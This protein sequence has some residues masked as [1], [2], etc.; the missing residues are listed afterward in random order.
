VGTHACVRKK[1]EMTPVG[2]MCP[3]RGIRFVVGP[4]PFTHAPGLLVLTPSL[5][6]VYMNESASRIM[7][8]LH[9][10]QHERFATDVLPGQVTALC[11]QA[12]MASHTL[13]GAKVCER[14]EYGTV[15]YSNNRPIRFHVFMVSTGAVGK[16]DYL[17]VVLMEQI[18]PALVLSTSGNQV[19]ISQREA[20]IVEF[21]MEGLTNKEIGVRLGISAFTVKDHLKRLMMKTKTSTRTGLIV[22]M[23]FMLSVSAPSTTHT[24]PEPSSL[25]TPESSTIV[26]DLRIA[27]VAAE[28][29]PEK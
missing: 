27:T 24:T 6:V 12:A 3:S 1:D 26:R 2:K 5:H 22:R 18:G 20:S 11:K 7:T 28:N 29:V 4:T 13:D 19:R 15:V 10:S 9:Q 14:H 25:L 21:L 16:M 8:C 23:V 17:F